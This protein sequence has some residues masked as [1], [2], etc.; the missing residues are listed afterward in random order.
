LLYLA[1]IHDSDSIGHHQG[2]ALI[3]CH[4]NEGDAE[5]FVEALYLEL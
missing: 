3:V 2:L 5:L 1:V 4:I